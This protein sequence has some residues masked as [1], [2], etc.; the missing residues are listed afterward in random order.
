MGAAVLLLVLLQ[1]QGGAMASEEPAFRT[2]RVWSL[3]VRLAA[4]GGTEIERVDTM[5]ADIAEAPVTTT[6]GDLLI[7]QWT[8]PDPRGRGISVGQMLAE[9]SRQRYKARVFYRTAAGQGG[10]RFLYFSPY[11]ASTNPIEELSLAPYAE[12]DDD[13][14]VS[15]I[16]RWMATHEFSPRS[17]DNPE[18]DEF[19]RQFG[20]LTRHFDSRMEMLIRLGHCAQER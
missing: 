5:R 1:A 16:K 11:G 3:W 7:F 8:V 15:H 12:G 4:C 2:N 6:A 20:R 10:V 9:M 17:T 19:S 18:R 13:R 14:S